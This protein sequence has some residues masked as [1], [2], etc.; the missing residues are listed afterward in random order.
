MQWL[1]A[2]SAAK[3]KMPAFRCGNFANTG[4]LRRINRLGAQPPAAELIPD[5]GACTVSTVS[6]EHRIEARQTLAAGNPRRIH[7]QITSHL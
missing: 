4:E 5:L 1:Q 6:D 3:G 7:S 2:G